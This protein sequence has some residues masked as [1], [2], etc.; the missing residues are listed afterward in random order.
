M[1]SLL[2]WPRGER[3]FDGVNQVSD[4]VPAENLTHE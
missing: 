1:G 3:V 2:G 4:F